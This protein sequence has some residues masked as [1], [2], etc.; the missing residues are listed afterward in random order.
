MTK[1]AEH[2]GFD[3]VIFTEEILNGTLHFLCNDMT[4]C[5]RLGETKQRTDILGRFKLAKVRKAMDKNSDSKQS[6]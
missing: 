2:C 6:K 1:S 4:K 3:L 5:R